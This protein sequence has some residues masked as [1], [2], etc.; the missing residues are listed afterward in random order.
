[1]Q[2]IVRSM[3]L[4]FW[5]ILAVNAVAMTAAI[6]GDL[7]RGALFSVVISL[8]ASFGFLLNDLWDRKVDE[9]NKARHFENSDKGTLAWGIAVSTGCLLSGMG[10]AMR[11]GPTELRIACV[12]GVGLMAY[13]VLLRRYLILPTFL[14]GF[15]AASPLW[16]PL[17]LWPHKVYAMHWVFVTAMILLLAARETLMDVRDREGDAAG[18]RDTMATVFGPG[19]A[20]S[21]A[22]VLLIAGTTLLCFVLI[23]QIGHLTVRDRFAAAT[24]ACVVLCL[25]MVPAHQVVVRNS[26]EGGDY[27]AVQRFVLQSRAAMILIP[28]LNLVMWG[29]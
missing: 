10:L 8:L 21:A 25:V 12:L 4:Y 2:T 14:A 20:K 16:A 28:L 11:L 23:A 1:M 13:T 5:P 6:G 9:I 22:A 17:I 19:I 7:K 3:R 27:G 24:T 29:R 15:V 18:G 26:V